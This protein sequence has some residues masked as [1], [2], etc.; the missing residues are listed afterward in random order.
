[1]S[2]FNHFFYIKFR[3]KLNRLKNES[4]KGKIKYDLI[5]IK[6]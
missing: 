2:I 1:M 4:K 3:F 5:D 6:I